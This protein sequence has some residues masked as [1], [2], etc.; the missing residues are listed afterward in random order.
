MLGCR[1]SDVDKARLCGLPALLYNSTMPAAADVPW[2]GQLETK[3]M[4]WQ[5]FARLQ[6]L[7]LRPMLHRIRDNDLPMFRSF[8][9]VL[10]RI[11][12]VQAF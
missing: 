4:W 5:I 9:C 12:T 11:S 7:R 3:L 1:V 8:S 2:I 6:W 10:S